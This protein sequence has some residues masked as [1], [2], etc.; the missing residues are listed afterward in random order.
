MI[1]IPLELEQYINHIAQV[2]HT[3]PQNWLTAKLTEVIEDYE[4]VL[5]ADNAKSNLIKGKDHLIEL[6]E[7]LARVNVAG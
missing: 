1:A 3:T 2:E 4:D 6:D 5:T 7:F